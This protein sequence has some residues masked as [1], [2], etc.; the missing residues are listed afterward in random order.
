MALPR[1]IALVGACGSLLAAGVLAAGALR[2]S[3]ARASLAPANR[4]N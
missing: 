4:V 1:S 2:L 3:R